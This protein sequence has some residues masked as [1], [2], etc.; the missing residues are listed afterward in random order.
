MQ[1]SLLEQTTFDTQATLGGLASVLLVHLALPLAWFVWHG[2][3][4]G[5]AEQPVEAGPPI[6]IIDAQIARLGKEIDP[7]KLPDRI[8]PALTTAPQDTAVSEKASMAITDAGTPPPDAKDDP[9]KR[10]GDRAQAFAEID[11]AKERE[12]DPNGSAEG[13]ASQTRGGD[14]YAAQLKAFVKD[15]WSAPT[16]IADDELGGLVTKVEVSIGADGRVGATRLITSSGNPT[17]DQ[18]VIAQLSSLEGKSIPPPPADV[19]GSYLGRAV[20][21][22]FSGRGSR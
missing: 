18:S 4:F 17:F 22:N 20:Q 7:S 19:A 3:H 14:L 16:L 5:D 9:I 15:G 13:N 1:P 8:A 10:L 11:Q 6:Q 12:G 21:F 2:F